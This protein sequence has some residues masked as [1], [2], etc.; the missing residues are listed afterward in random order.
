MEHITDAERERGC[1]N[2]NERERERAR[3]REQGR[4]K[5]RARAREFVRIDKVLLHEV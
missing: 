2:L 1:Q 4:D 3:E 5:D